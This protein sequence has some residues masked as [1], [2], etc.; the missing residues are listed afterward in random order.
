[1]SLTEATLCTYPFLR[2]PA[3]V[4]TEPPTKPLLGLPSFVVALAASGGYSANSAQ[5]QF[6][7]DAQA[8]M[9]LPMSRLEIGLNNT[10]Y[11]VA[12]PDVFLLGLCYAA[13]AKT[14][15]DNLRD[16]VGPPYAYLA[17]EVKRL[18]KE[19]RRMAIAWGYAS[20]KLANLPSLLD[21][22]MD[23]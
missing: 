4:D 9:R 10:N 11:D 19:N 12:L 3:A 13:A 18:E 2:H 17:D 16:G 15:R 14:A 5:E 6:L 1:M 22:T 21:E 8:A 7:R 23:G 20:L